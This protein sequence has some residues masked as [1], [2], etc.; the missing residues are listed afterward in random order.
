[1]TQKNI[2]CTDHLNEAKSKQN[3]NQRTSYLF[4]GTIDW[5]EVQEKQSRMLEVLAILV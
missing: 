2:Y 5:E 3:Y 4:K 1:M